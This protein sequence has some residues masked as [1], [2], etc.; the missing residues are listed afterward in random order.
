MIQSRLQ[1]VLHAMAEQQLDQM[2]VS[3]PAAIFYLTGKWFSPGERMLALYLNRSGSHKLLVNQLFPVTQDLGVELVSYQDVQDPVSI[4][5]TLVEREKP[6][7]VD[8]QW[9]ARF[10]LPLME[11]GGGSRFL[12]SSGILD[13]IRL[14]KD[15]EE[16]RL[17][18]ASSHLND[19]AMERLQGCLT[20]GLTEKQVGE[21]LMEIYQDLGS[22][23]FSF[24][25]IVAF[26][27]HSADPHHESQPGALA[28]PGDAITL[29]MG[30]IKENYCS[31]MTRTVFLGQ[32]SPKQRQVYE[33]VRQANLAAIAAVKP[34]ARFCDVDKAARDTIAAA[35]YGERF[36]HRTGHAIGLECHEFGDVS[37]S[38]TDLLE[39]GMIF[40]IEPGVYLEGEF[41]IRI[42]DLVL[43]TQDGCEVLNRLTKDLTVL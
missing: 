37:Q 43:V 5:A 7:G 24:P 16:I 4:L 11:Q 2:L 41:G 33:L 19:L 29:D 26:G 36:L 23:L 18:R 31:D 40:S 12:N 32:P 34:G 25:P 10:L 30:C 9:P 15:Q 3:D 28:K 20:Q 38:N 42:E 8:K 17:M 27:V 1:R 6:L 39:P 22:D 14:V 21:R 35:G 13:R